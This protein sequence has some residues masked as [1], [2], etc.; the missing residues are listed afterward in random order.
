MR[1]RIASIAAD[2]PACASGLRAGDEIDT[3]SGVRPRDVLDYARLSADP[4]AEAVLGD[5]RTVPVA[6]LSGATLDDAVFDGVKTCDNHCSFCFIYQLPKQMRPS[7][8]LKDDDYRLSAMY[9]NFTT[10]TR[11]TE[12]DLERVLDERIEPLHV[13]IHAT[14]PHVRAGMLRNPKGGMSLRWLRAV[15]DAGL[16]VHGQVVCCPGVNDADVLDATIAALLAGY[17]E[18]ASVGVVPLGVSRFN[19]EDGL[20]AP[21]PDDASATLEAIHAWQAVALERLGRRL[22]F[23]SDE[24]YLVA[25]VGFPA[26]HEYEGFPQHE[27]GIGMARAL[28]ADLTP[29]PGRAVGAPAWGYRAERIPDAASVSA[30]RGATRV[31]IMSGELGARVVGPLVADRSDVDVVAVPNRFFG[32][33]VG[34]TGLLTGTDLAHAISALDPGVEAVVPD[35]VFHEGRTLDEWSAEDLASRT[36]RAVR[37]VTTDAAGLRTAVGSG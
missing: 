25:G 35:V 6:A 36:G 37:V 15:L 10:L 31:A 3:V 7:L 28:E 2:S 19:S 14:D 18:L 5:G 12:A 13:S 24:W 23:A 34:V 9:G 16:E 20:R 21:T 4:D 8:Y 27:N 11:F 29:A 17:P 22:V 1:I 26:A 33:N 32:G 30:R